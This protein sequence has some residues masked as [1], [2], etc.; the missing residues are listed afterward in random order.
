MT[1]KMTQKIN[2]TTI[3]S[4]FSEKYGM[5]VHPEE[6]KK[7]GA[8]LGDS[9]AFHVS[10]IQSAVKSNIKYVGIS[11]CCFVLFLLLLDGWI[12]QLLGFFSVVFFFLLMVLPNT[13]VSYLKKSSSDFHEIGSLGLRVVKN[14][15]VQLRER[16]DGDRKKYF[17][18]EW[19]QNKD[20]KSKVNEFVA[21]IPSP[22]EMIQFAMLGY[23][24]PALSMAITKKIPNRWIRSSLQKFLNGVVSKL[25]EI[26]ISLIP[27]SITQM[28]NKILNNVLSSANVE[29]TI[30]G[31]MLSPIESTLESAIN[32]VFDPLIKFLGGAA[33]LVDEKLSTV[34]KFALGPFIAVKYVLLVLA[35][36]PSLVLTC[37]YVYSH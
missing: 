31:R 14:V 21:T 16:I 2:R 33:K 23:F 20:F 27:E 10:I 19:D 37:I 1:Q 12:W 9:L 15:V 6:I 34:F 11:I 29:S 35:V 30:S 7:M 22:V 26:V 24:S 36:M 32:S 4:T 25:T 18:D 3:I 8:L 13:I 17:V 28:H 5:T